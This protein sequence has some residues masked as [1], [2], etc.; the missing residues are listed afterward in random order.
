MKIKKM[1]KTEYD[2][3][4]R[5]PRS[6]KGTNDPRNLSRVKREL[7]IAYHKLFGNGTPHDI[8]R[9]LNKIWIDPDFHLVVT[10]KN[11][12]KTD[13]LKWKTR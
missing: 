8:A 9:I 12:K 5:L 4:H 10:E 2:T 3:H 1:K 11:P 6:R 13:K 7:H